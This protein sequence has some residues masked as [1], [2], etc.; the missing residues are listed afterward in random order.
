MER[1]ARIG[2]AGA[3]LAL[4]IS[5][6]GGAVQSGV[7]VGQVG[8]DLGIYAR[9]APQGAEACAL[10]EALAALPGSEKPVSDVCGKAA[11]SDLLWRRSLEVLAAYGETLE[12][13]ARGSGAERAGRLE[14]ALTG[15]SG[16]DWIAVD[17][18]S[19][20]AARDAAA[21]LV[22][23][24][25]EGA[26]GDLGIA[27]KNAAPH[28]KTLCDGLD[29]ALQ[30]AAKT[31]AEVQK[32]AEKKRSSRADRRC[33]TAAGTNVC[34]SE[35]PI[36]RMV[37]GDVFAQ[38][39]LLESTHLETRDALLGFCAAH[40]KLEAAAAEGNLSKDRTYDEVVDAVK[41]ARRAPPPGDAKPGAKP[42]KK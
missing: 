3:V 6:C 27:V 8:H 12:S 29:A 22:K 23:Q 9:A 32:E 40:K 34:V 33:G 10:Q 11:K 18:A 1:Q 28:V 5:G 13:L 42:A 38:A 39:A 16:N 17:G 41:A 2:R 35:S 26:G 36:D 15:V 24:M 19:E 37:Y 20:Q 25:S 4:A 21:A 14:A 7:A 31:F 30:A